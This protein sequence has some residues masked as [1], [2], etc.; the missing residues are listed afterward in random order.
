METILESMAKVLV[1]FAIPTTIGY[2]LTRGWRIVA[3]VLWL[4]LPVFVVV[5]LTV[6]AFTLS[7]P[8]ETD[9][10]LY[11]QPFGYIFVFGVLSF[12]VCSGAGFAVGFTLRR[13]RS[14]PN[15]KA[16]I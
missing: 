15:A 9:F 8:D 2:F 6:R 13:K 7:A 14:R 11:G 5:G 16:G 3:I 4:L 12:A 1:L 10:G